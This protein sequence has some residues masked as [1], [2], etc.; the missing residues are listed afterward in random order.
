M[1]SV[2]MSSHLR[3]SRVGRASEAS[4]SAGDGSCPGCKGEVLA[5]LGEG[6]V[7]DMD[8]E[9]RFLDAFLAVEMTCFASFSSPNM[10]WRVG[11]GA[12]ERVSGL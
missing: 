9:V 5:F 3:R 7:P 11:K 12:L 10:D 1:I 8:E 6:E 4:S 2:S